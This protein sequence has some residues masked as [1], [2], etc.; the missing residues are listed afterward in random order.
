MVNILVA[1]DSADNR[2]LID[3]VLRVRGFNTFF[4]RDGKEALELVDNLR[5]DLIILDIN[6]PEIDGFEVCAQLKSNAATRQIPVLMLTALADIENRV[7]GLGLGADDYVTKPFSPRELIARVNTRLRLKGEADELRAT[8]E[9][10]RKTF[11][12]FVPANVVETLLKNP[13]L[14]ELGG[15]VQ[16]VTILFADMEGFTTAAEHADPVQ[17][18][19]VLNHYHRLLVDNV[20]GQEGTLD[21]F[22]GDGIMA[23]FNTPLKQEDHALRA[24][25]AALNIRAELP[26]LHKNFEPLFRL[27]VNV[28]IHSGEAIVGNIGT[29]DL[30]DYTALGDTVN[31]ASRLQALSE[32]GDI[33]ITE[34]VYRQ[35]REH[36]IVEDL[37]PQPIRGRKGMVNVYQ[38]LDRTPEAPA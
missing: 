34:A 6:M 29:A 24:V 4:A 28:G 11:E 15:H 23:L 37:G 30:M 27:N 31:V 38:V 7:K 16:D 9:Q 20:M 1:D 18:L 25:R 19:E 32:N 2:Q 36:I 10:I 21:K 3:D 5:P 12:R 17:L 13:D 26:E 35:L 14:V 22:I 33:L 8:Q